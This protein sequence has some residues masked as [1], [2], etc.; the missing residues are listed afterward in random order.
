MCAPQ[1]SPAH[2]PARTRSTSV[3]AAVSAYWN[4][5]LLLS[6]RPAFPYRR[7]QARRYRRLLCRPVQ[8]APR[9]SLDRGKGPCQHV[10]R[11]MALAVAQSGR[12]PLLSPC[13]GRSR[14]LHCTRWKDRCRHTPQA[15]WI[16]CMPPPAY[17]RLPFS[18]IFGHVPPCFLL[19]VHASKRFYAIPY[20]AEAVILQSSEKGPGNTECFPALLF[21]A[22]FMVTP[23]PAPVRY[24]PEYLQYFQYRRRT[25]SDPA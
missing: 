24:P 6:G 12:I 17:K 2:I 16:L 25:E 1:T 13:H 7:A 5:C 15:H 22:P 9:T 8:G 21:C 10:P 19:P 4:L 23:G 14:Y 18:R 11:R 20:P 3:Q